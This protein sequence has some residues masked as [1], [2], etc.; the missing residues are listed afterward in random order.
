MRAQVLWK[1]YGAV[2]V[3]VGASIVCEFDTNLVELTSSLADGI[4]GK[5]CSFVFDNKSRRF[6]GRR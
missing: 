1:L 2:R 3:G 4:E 5:L 6:F